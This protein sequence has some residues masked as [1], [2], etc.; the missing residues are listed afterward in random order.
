MTAR[1]GAKL[2][3]TSNKNLRKKP[4]A[5]D[6]IFQMCNNYKLEVLVLDDTF[7]TSLSIAMIFDQA[8]KAGYDLDE[9]KEIVEQ[10]SEVKPKKKTTPKKKVT[11]KKS[12]KVKS[13]K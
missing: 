7:Y 2:M 3:Q 10:Y 13:K 9:F 11:K 8:G 12:K 6:E 1:V 5:L 4:T